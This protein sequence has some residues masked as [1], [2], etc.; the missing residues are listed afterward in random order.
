MAFFW[1]LG[2]SNYYFF[3]SFRGGSVVKSST[4]LLFQRNGVRFPAPRW[5]LTTV[6]NSSARIP[7][8]VKKTNRGSYAVFM[9]GDKEACTQKPSKP[10]HTSVQH[11]LKLAFSW[12]VSYL[13]L[14]NQQ[15]KL[16]GLN[17]GIISHGVSISTHKTVSKE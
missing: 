3:L 7:V 14:H 5:C 2:T 1:C 16:W 15:A 11:Q 6:C 13:F 12:L 17:Q 4:K 8:L 9:D 10:G